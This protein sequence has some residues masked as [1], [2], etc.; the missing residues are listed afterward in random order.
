MVK[1]IKVAT[2]GT[3][4]KTVLESPRR[5]SFGLQYKIHIKNCGKINCKAS[6][7]TSM[8]PP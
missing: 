4:K 8:L 5:N 6:I 7:T 3:I 2:H 1:H